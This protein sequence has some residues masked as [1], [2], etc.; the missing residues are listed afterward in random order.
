MAS[1]LHTKAASK[2]PS[3]TSLEA[4]KDF[5]QHFTSGLYQV[6]PIDA[7]VFELARSLSEQ[8]GRALRN[9]ALDVLH[10]AAAVQFG[11]SAFATFD[12]RQ[13]R[14][15]EEVGLTLLR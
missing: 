9:R 7:N 4:Y 14:L 12:D 10:V 15:A 3:R 1:S 11:A 8:H 5:R 2:L 13:G 6:V